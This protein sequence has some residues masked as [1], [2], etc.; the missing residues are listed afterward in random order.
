MAGRRV[1]ENGRTVSNREILSL[2]IS[3]SPARET[4]MRTNIQCLQMTVKVP[5]GYVELKRYNSLPSVITPH[6]TSQ[7]RTRM[8]Y[9]DSATLLLPHCLY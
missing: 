7:I 9:P 6:P 3:T 4:S 1:S 5:R 8:A 2:G